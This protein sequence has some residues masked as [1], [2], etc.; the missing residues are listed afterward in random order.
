MGAENTIRRRLSTGAELVP[1]RVGA[2]FRVFA[3]KRKRVDIVVESPVTTTIRLEREADGHFSGLGE[4][5]GPGTLYRLR[6][7]E[8]DRLFPDPASRFQPEGPHGPS[9]IVDPSSFVW[10]DQT[11]PG[12]SLR[13][14]V[15]YELHL[16]TFTP[17][18]TYAAAA[19][20]LE[21]LRDVG[22][23]LIELMPVAEFAGRFGWGYD[24]VDL[25]APTRLYGR[26]DDLRAFVDRAHALGLGVILDVVY[27]HLGPSGNYLRELSDDFFTDRHPN[28]WGEAIDFETA[29]GAREYFAANGAY[30]VDEFHIDGLRLDATQ[31]IY[32]DSADHIVGEIGSRARAAAAQRSI[33]IFAETES[34]ESRLV[35]PLDQGGRGLDAMWNDDFH[36]AARVAATG[37]N[38]AYYEPTKGTAQELVSAAKWGFLFQGQRSTFHDAPRGEPALDLP[39]PAFTLYL[40]NH[41]QVSNSLEG[42]RLH[43]LTSPGV[44]RA[45]TAL[46]LLAPGTPLLFQGQEFAAS[47]PFVFFADHEPELA[48]LVA[49]GRRKLLARFPSLAGEEAQR[50]IP[51][52]HAP[53]AF[54]R[55]KLDHSER[56]KNKATYDLFKD[57]LR[58]RRED[59]VF[60]AQDS[61]RLAGAVIGRRAFALRFGL[62]SGDERLVLVN[63]GDDMVDVETMAEP[64]VAPP[65]GTSWK[66]LFDTEEPRY[67]GEGMPPRAP[68]GGLCVPAGATLVLAP[69]S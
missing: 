35:R 8:D 63:L 11:W 2:H 21:E 37:R 17:E 41:D 16:G 23:T 22:I 59:P 34:Q 1:G 67:G 9:E 50:R 52:P 49:E 51:E 42:A 38:E 7:D 10:T 58:L 60:A 4:G 13:G 68:N 69:S 66:L 31:C 15:V 24:G 29:R 36:H 33:V 62:G 44:H 54:E 39:A 32:D 47:A 5:L 19:R 61:T 28:E 48:K 43:Q 45:L 65:I 18:G 20:E 12:P 30:W 56:T 64:L 55:C 27:N 6:L 46:L 57:L 26:P 40:E 3:P 25:Y 53:A 14:Q